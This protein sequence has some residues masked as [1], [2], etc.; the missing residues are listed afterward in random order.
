MLSLRNWQ[1][2]LSVSVGLCSCQSTLNTTC[3]KLQ[4]SL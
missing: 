3:Y 2:M 4:S 1:A